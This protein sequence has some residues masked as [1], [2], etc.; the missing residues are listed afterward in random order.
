MSYYAG[1]ELSCGLR[2]ATAHRGP[3]AAFPGTLGCWCRMRYT[4]IDIPRKGIIP[5]ITLIHS[6]WSL[7][8][9]ES[10]CFAQWGEG[11]GWGVRGTGPT[12][13]TAGQ[14]SGD[15]RQRPRLSTVE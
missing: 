5:F 12:E 1:D 2:W 7:T 14:R 6:A 13:Q 3:R 9:V 8:P 15:Q 11:G 4:R 10:Y